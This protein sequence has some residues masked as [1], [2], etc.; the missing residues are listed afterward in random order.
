MKKLLLLLS[1]VIGVSGGVIAPSAAQT[2]GQT[3]AQAAARSNPQGPTT[4]LTIVSGQKTHSFNVEL[5]D[6][7]EETA[8]GLMYRQ[9]MPRDHGMI[10]KFA[11][12]TS[13]GMW[14]K[15]CVFPQDMLFLDQD[16]TVL[17]M[18]ENARP[19]SMRTITPGFPYWSV[20]E[21][22]GGVVKELG[23]KPGDRVRHAIFNNLDAG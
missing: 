9:S 21:L 12:P 13:T 3:P 20:L 17:A 10:F 7:P 6:T 18:A 5:A 16:G 8:L 11:A 14:M 2:P 1:L 4:P 19:G 22:N 15:D 23:L